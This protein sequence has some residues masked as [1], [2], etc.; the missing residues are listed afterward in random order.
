MFT[1]PAGRF[2]PGACMATDA[3]I[4]AKAYA[5]HGRLACR[6][7]DRRRGSIRGSVDRGA[8]FRT[9]AHDRE[10]LCVQGDRTKW[11]AATPR[12]RCERPTSVLDVA[13]RNGLRYYESVARMCL[14][15]ARARYGDADGLA[16]FRGHGETFISQGGRLLRAVVSRSARRTRSRADVRGRG[17]DFDRSSDRI[18]PQG[19]HPIH[20]RPAAPH[21]RR[22][23]AARRDPDER[24]P[25]RRSLPRPPSPSRASRARAASACKRR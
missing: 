12:R 9:R 4:T 11:R 16:Q 13:E 22:H 7:C 3:G 23:P 19:R 18:G 17:A 24:R 20:R 15:W 5:R 2:P 6:R 10:Y 14:D 21:P 1:V 25:G 8:R